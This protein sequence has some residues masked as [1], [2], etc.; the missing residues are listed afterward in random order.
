[1]SCALA[2]HTGG[3]QDAGPRPSLSHSSHFVQRGCGGTFL[4]VCLKVKY[5][6]IK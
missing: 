6:G 5:L 2:L 3:R 1:M 4:T